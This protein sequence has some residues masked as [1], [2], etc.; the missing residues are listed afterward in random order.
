[1]AYEYDIFLSY[2]RHPESRQWLVEHFQPL[3]EFHVELELGRKV[4]V[5][6]DDQDD[7]AG[8]SWP[9]H[10]GRALGNS[11]TLV[12]LWTRTYFHSEWCSRELSTMLARERDERFRTAE[13]PEGLIFPVVLHDCEQLPPKLPPMQ[14]VAM[15]ECFQVRMARNSQTAEI[16]AQQISKRLAPG[17]ASAVAAAPRWRAKWPLKTAGKFLAAVRRKGPPRQ[18]QLPRHSR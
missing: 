18:T 2:K 8:T 4:T 3:L 11:R 9:A 17:V 13:R 15:Q 16:L 5:F 6:R 10:L 12:A 1:M 14:F 7:E